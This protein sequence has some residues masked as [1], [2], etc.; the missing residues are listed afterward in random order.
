MLRK[1]HFPKPSGAEKII[2]GSMI[3]EEVRFCY[4]M[5]EIKRSFV[6]HKKHPNYLKFGGLFVHLN[7]YLPVLPV[8]K[9]GP[10]AQIPAGKE[11][12]RVYGHLSIEQR[13]V[14][15]SGQ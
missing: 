7:F 12:K 1:L 11:G 5:D 9:V 14:K 8:V 6:R 15:I 10:L 3:V 2:N 4:N 13:T